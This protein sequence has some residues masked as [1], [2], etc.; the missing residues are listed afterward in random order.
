MEEALNRALRW[1][2]TAPIRVTE[3][4]SPAH[5]AILHGL[6]GEV[7]LGVYTEITGYAVS[8]FV[9]LARSEA[10][11]SYLR[12]AEDA[13]GFL[14]RIQTRDGAYPHLPD[15]S[16]PEG[17]APMYS[18]DTAAC[19]V[20]LARLA[21]MT[22]D[23]RYL[24]SGLAAGRWLLGM[25]LPDGSFRAMAV[26]GGDVADPGGFFGDRSCIH[27]KVAIALLELGELSGRQEFRRAALRACDY[28][29]TMQAPDGAFWSR[30]DR[31]YVFT[32]AH[33]YACEGLWFAG[34]YLRESRYMDAARRGIA[35]LAASQR[36]D[37][38][39]LSNYRLS[40][41][42]RAG[43]REAFLR[44]RPSD[45]AAQAARLFSLLGSECD[46][47]RRAAIAFLLECQEPAGGFL[48]RKTR[49][50]QSPHRFSWCAQFAIQAL[51]WDHGA[52]AS[53]DLF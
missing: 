30:P 32:H 45:A 19:A 14:L 31:G 26:R 11:P 43:A 6:E 4:A 7:P 35:W 3:P 13:A 16:A 36:P 38:G 47:P 27:A 50:G 40:V 42:S 2:M 8:L 10:D 44:P 29:L 15:P 53:G 34:S 41:F 1:H 23:D 21:R 22:K 17:P 52:A 33:C 46:A 49:L 9:F 37:G 39:W 20:G 12:A 18:F 51:V 5:G 28:A 48:Y 24:E 25:Q